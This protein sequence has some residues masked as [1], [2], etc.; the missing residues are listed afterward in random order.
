MPLM[1]FGYMILSVGYLLLG[2]A[3][4]VTDLVGIEQSELNVWIGVS[5]SGLGAAFGVIPTYNNIF[6]YAMH[7]D[8]ESQGNQGRG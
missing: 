5:S 6:G 2:P 7:S 3:K 4:W 1:V 8:E